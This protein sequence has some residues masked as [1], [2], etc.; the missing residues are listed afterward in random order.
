MGRLAVTNNDFAEM[1]TTLEML[2]GV[3]RLLKRECLIDHRPQS[4]Q[5]DGSRRMK[6]C[7]SSRM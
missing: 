6:A 1:G 2:V 4:M 7:E 5:R 3:E